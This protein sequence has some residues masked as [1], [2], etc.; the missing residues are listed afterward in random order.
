MLGL[1][2]FMMYEILGIKTDLSVWRE[3]WAGIE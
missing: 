2:L 1:F 3:W